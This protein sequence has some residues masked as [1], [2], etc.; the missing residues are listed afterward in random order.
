MDRSLKIIWI[1]LLLLLMHGAEGF[2]LK[3]TGL[4]KQQASNVRLFVAAKS[5]DCAAL[6]SPISQQHKDFKRQIKRALQPFGFFNAKIK[7]TKV[8]QGACD[9][10]NV[11]VDTG[12]STTLRNVKTEI[13]GEASQDQAFQ[14]LLKTHKLE[15]GQPLYQ[16][17]YER[18]KS[19]LLELANERLYL[20][21]AFAVQQLD[22]F[23]ELNQ[24]DVNLR[25]ESG[26]RY[27]IGQVNIEMGA[28]FL[29]QEMVR[30]LINIDVPATVNQSQLYGIKQKL[31]ATGYFRQVLFELDHEHKAA[32]T[33]P[34]NIKLLPAAKYDYSVGLGFSTDA[35]AKASFS[36][37]N[38]RINQR[39]HQF[40]SQ[41]ELSQLSNELTAAYKIPSQQRP[42]SK[43]F[44]VQLGY[45]DE[46]TDLVDSQTAKL[47]FSETR[48]HNN[49][50][51]NINFIDIVHEQFDTG[52]AQGE[53]LL[54]VPGLSWSLTD[55]DN[56]ARP[57]R[58]YKIQTEFKGA[59]E[60]LFSDASFAQI[61]LS[62]KFI[63]ALGASNRMLYRAQFG[64][65]AS[66]DF[67]QL[68]TTYRFFA[69]GDQ[70]IRGYDYESL[71]PVNEAGDLAG[72]KHLAVASIEFEHQFAPQWA[73]AAFT[74][75]GDAFAD[76]FDLKYSVG[77]GLRWFSPI[78]PIRIDVGVPLDQD[79]TKVR[80]H[81]TV[82]PDL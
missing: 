11:M 35:G 68:P 19:K 78:G 40:S 73:V 63:H 48:I 4:N 8:E 52:E 7:L 50:W 60:D 20:D 9:H 76:E 13:D 15:P 14:Q 41:L 3:L 53:S 70:S 39:G 54:L 77:A 59:S 38:H 21:A 69:G 10:V 18:L 75:F 64:A 79:D 36:Y 28:S 49:R 43:W 72:G 71:S 80:L 32:G 17:D 25:F 24:A 6:Q 58:G 66:A 46:Q 74:D 31:N 26:S 61:T 65:T 45:R 12:P 44:S 34:L 27:Q 33:V 47:G 1:G 82:G 5:Y 67:E 29:R 62:G 2:E 81:V 23:P 55:A 51:Q 22:V 42:A 30:G 56:L 57:T 16:P 37:D